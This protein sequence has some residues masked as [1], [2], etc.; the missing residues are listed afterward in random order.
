MRCFSLRTRRKNISPRKQFLWIK[1][2]F[3]WVND[4]FVDSK[5]FS[6]IQRNRFIYI[7]KN[8]F[9][10]TKISSIQRNVFFD[11]ISKKCF[12]DSKKLI[13]QC[14]CITLGKKIWLN[15]RTCNF[16][17]LFQQKY[18]LNQLKFFFDRTKILLEQQKK[19]TGC[20]STILLWIQQ[21]F[22]LREVL[23]QVCAHRSVV[24]NWFLNYICLSKKAHAS[25]DKELH[26]WIQLELF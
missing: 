19:I 12:F 11:R 3:L 18:L 1:E 5:K 8:F 25:N 21:I 20:I 7:K 26:S 15:Q 22:F 17:L 16:L 2:T 6:L 14:C 23:L 13:S 9:A 4:S 24:F 10:L